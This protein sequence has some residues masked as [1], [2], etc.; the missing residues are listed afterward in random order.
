MRVRNMFHCLFGNN[1]SNVTAFNADNQKEEKHV[2]H[3][4]ASDFHR[5]FYSSQCAPRS[6][7]KR[8]Y[9]LV[10]EGAWA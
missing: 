1:V 10:S 4:S 5:T 2:E 7:G 3:E 6:G 8:E 9:E